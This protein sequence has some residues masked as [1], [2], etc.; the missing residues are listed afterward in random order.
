M[1]LSSFTLRTVRREELLKLAEYD[2]QVYGQEYVVPINILQSWYD[3]NPD[4]FQVLVNEEDQ[5]VGYFTMM[6][7]R[8]EVIQKL[9]LEEIKES[10]IR[11]EDILSFHEKSY[12]AYFCAFA[13][14]IA[15]RNKRIVRAL[16]NAA[17]DY[18]EKLYNTKR[19]KNIYAMIVSNAGNKIANIAAT[20]LLKDGRGLVIKKL[21]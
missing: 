1:H 15:Y 9:L 7:L 5:I 14:P 4:V 21:K 13:V 6:P 10:D 16:I 11:P 20:H 8:T 2:Y 3:K 17:N 19:L 12:D 18:V